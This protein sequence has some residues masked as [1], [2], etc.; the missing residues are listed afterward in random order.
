NGTATRKEIRVY[1]S[2]DSRYFMDILFYIP[3]RKDKPAPLFLGLNFSGNQTIHA[4]TGITITKRW[5]AYGEEP[6][7]KCHYAPAASRG[8]AAEAWPVEQIIAAGYG[9]GTIYYGDL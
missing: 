9:L 7:C 3:N 8:T 6:A 4:D 5:V 2:G 1:F